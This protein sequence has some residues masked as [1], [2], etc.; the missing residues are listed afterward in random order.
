MNALARVDDPFSA[1]CFCFVLQ[2]TETDDGGR[3]IVYHASGEEFYCNMITFLWPFK[4]IRAFFGA[5]EITFFAVTGLARSI[6]HISFLAKAS[7]Y[8]LS[9]ST[10]KKETIVRLKIQQDDFEVQFE[11]LRELY[12]EVSQKRDVVQA[13]FEQGQK[14]MGTFVFGS[15]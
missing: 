8:T 14:L 9:A 4:L 6:T 1:H 12:K 7:F 3:G 15:S 11:R 10:Q 5:V 13:G 2:S